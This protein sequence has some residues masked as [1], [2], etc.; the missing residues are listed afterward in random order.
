MDFLELCNYRPSQRGFIGSTYSVF[1]NLGQ[2]RYE[3]K[4]GLLSKRLFKNLLIY[5]LFVW[6]LPLIIIWLDIGWDLDLKVIF[7]ETPLDY[8]LN[9]YEV[10]GLDINIQTHCKHLFVWSFTFKS[11]LINVVFYISVTLTHSLSW[12]IVICGCNW[13]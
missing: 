2:L 8:T 11:P 1:V 9:S 6:K 10:V 13:G 5:T 4:L 7:K 3:Q 12:E